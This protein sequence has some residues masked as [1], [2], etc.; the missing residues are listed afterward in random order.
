MQAM[1]ACKALE[2]SI[3]DGQA[4]NHHYL[5]VP[6]RAA[7]CTARTLSSQS[8]SSSSSRICDMVWQG[9]SA[10]PRPKPLPEPTH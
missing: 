7:S 3:M 6:L 10:A 2:D 8:S 9:L 1:L 4:I 5:Q